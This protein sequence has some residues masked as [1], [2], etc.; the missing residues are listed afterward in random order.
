MRKAYLFH[1]RRPLAIVDVESVRTYLCVFFGACCSIRFYLCELL[2]CL[3]LFYSL[4]FILMA[5]L[6]KDLDNW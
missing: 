3:S 2:I 5:S 4:L 1:F 6:F